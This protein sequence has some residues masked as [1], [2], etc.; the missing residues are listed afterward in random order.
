VARRSLGCAALGIAIGC[1]GAAVAT[2]LM[3]GLLFGVSATD[4]LTF[5]SA[6]GA[7]AITAVLASYLPALRAARV[8]P[9]TTL[10]A[11]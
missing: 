8:A 10:R 4:P 1:V 9:A 6:A 2:R 3:T 5:F 7:L 11:D